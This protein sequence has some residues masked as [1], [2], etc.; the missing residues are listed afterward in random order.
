[1]CYAC[2]IRNLEQRQEDILS[3]IDE[4][5]VRKVME[6]CRWEIFY[7]KVYFIVS[8]A[9]FAR[10]KMCSKNK[11]IYLF[12]MYCKEDEPVSLSKDSALLILGTVIYVSMAL[13]LVIS[14]F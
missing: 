11:Y 12:N 14:L 4:F 10:E 8:P 9:R 13:K 3:G 5:K 7:T 2:Y 6:L 1:M